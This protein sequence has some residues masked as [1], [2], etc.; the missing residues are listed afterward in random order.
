MYAK[1]IIRLFFNTK[2]PVNM[3][4]IVKKQTEGIN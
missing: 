4:N 3:L 2:F 1:Y